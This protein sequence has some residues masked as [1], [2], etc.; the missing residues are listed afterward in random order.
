MALLV[1]IQAPTI[2]TSAQINV[3]AAPTGLRTSSVS[4]NSVTIEWDDP[5]DDSIIGYQ[6]LRRF[7]DG[8]R[9]GDHQGSREFEPV[10]ED[11]GSVSTTY[12][13]ETVAPRTRYV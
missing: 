7:V 9:Y 4:Y 11:T 6:L 3:P 8:S 1:A 12:T 10:V 2:E 13:D 5:D